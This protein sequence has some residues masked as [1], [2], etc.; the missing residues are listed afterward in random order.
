M[1]IA[2]KL[3]ILITALVL[4]APLSYANFCVPPKPPAKPA[5]PDEKCPACEPAECKKCTA[6]PVML[7]LGSYTRDETD[8]TIRTTGFGITVGRS[9]DSGRA[10]DGPMGIGWT[11]SLTSR[12][13]YAVYAL[14]GSTYQHRAVI[15]MPHGGIYEFTR[16]SSTGAFTPPVG[17]RDTLVQ[18]G[19]GTYDM[20]LGNSRTV[21]H[22]NADGTLS[23]MK[24]EFNNA[25]HYT[26]DGSGRIQRV[27]DGAGSGRFVDV[28]WNTATG[29]I[30]SVTD[31]TGRTV[32]YTYD[33]SGN[34]ESVANAVTPVGE[35]SSRYYYVA[36]RFKPLLSR[37]EDRWDR[38]ISRIEWEAGDKVK[39]YTDGDF[40]DGNPTASAGE[41]YRYFYPSGTS[42]QRTH[43]LGSRVY[44]FAAATGLK[45]NDGTTFNAS[46]QVAASF[47]DDGRSTNYT[48]DSTGRILTE[49]VH[50]NFGATEV[51][52]TYTYDPTF[53]DKI[54]TKKP[55]NPLL[56][57]GNRFEYWA[58]GNPA[59]G[60]LK[61]VYQIRTDGVTEDLVGTY[62]Y[63]A[64][65]R[66]LSSGATSASPA[67][68]YTYTAAGDL[69]TVTQGG[70]QVRYEYDAL[71]RM[72][73]SIDELNEETTY[74][75]DDAGR[76]LTLTRPKLSAMPALDFTTT[77]TY[78]EY[79][80]TTG[81]T[82]TKTTD[83]NGRVT[84]QGYDALGNLVK[85]VDALQNAT[86][87]TY[88]YNLLKS[89][90]DANDNTTSY[91][92]DFNRN[93]ISTTF[94]DGEIES[95]TRSSRGR[96]NSVTD[97]RGTTMSYAYDAFGRVT[98]ATSDKPSP[99][100][101]TYR[102][103]YSYE[104]QKLKM[105]TDQMLSPPKFY[106]FT[107][108]DRFQV[109][110]EGYDNELQV[111]Y[112]RWSSGVGGPP[113]SY[114]L[115]PPAG[116]T[117]RVT[118]V[119]YTYDSR[120]RVRTISFGGPT[121]DVTISY[122]DR[123]QYDEI[124]FG[125]GMVR[126]FTYDDQG[127]LTRVSHTH[128]TTGTIARH[129]YNYDFNHG[130]STWT[131][132]GQRVTMDPLGANPTK[133]RFDAAYQ[134][135]EE[136]PP[137]GSYRRYHY[138]A[139]GNRTGIEYPGGAVQDFEYYK[140]GSNQN[141]SRL[142]N[143]FGNTILTYDENGNQAN[144]AT[145][146][147]MN[148]LTQYGSVTFEYDWRS[149]R[150]KRQTASYS[151]VGKNVA[152][153][154]ETAT[155]VLDDFIFGAGLDE[156]L[157]RMNASGTK[158][159][160]AVDGLGSIVA[161]V[162]A[163]GATTHTSSYDAWGFTNS[164][165]TFGYTGRETGVGSLLYYRARYY[166]TAYGRFISEDAVRWAHAVTP[167]AYVHNDPLSF[168]DPEGMCDWEIRGRW[169][170][171]LPHSPP[172]YHHYLHNKKTGQSIGFS[173]KYPVLASFSPIGAPGIWWTDEPG[174]SKDKSDVHIADIKDE[175]CKC[176]G[177]KAKNPGS[178]P[179]YCLLPDPTAQSK[180]WPGGGKC[181]NCQTWVTNVLDDCEN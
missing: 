181:E 101:G 152:R 143:A 3:G 56:W 97:R 83:P 14:S 76:I 85:T 86:T 34:L 78:D 80:A 164:P 105:V 110:T 147:I 11:S 120:N 66:L 5:P 107:Y 111:E 79:D 171:G 178:P 142:K 22:F 82:F 70:D 114:T 39:S 59:P 126:K 137:N 92:Y 44:Q 141:T 25:I 95:Y 61:K 161:V 8:L 51:V 123:S 36:G 63:D 67:V 68:T 104:G 64:R 121:P 99:S 49:T 26:Y 74:T 41:K 112:E 166:E 7:S 42:T 176:V 30:S 46:G 23:W 154:R 21:L 6:S 65:G 134:L 9:Y 77:L 93:L 4:F 128:P 144:S 180:P 119:A 69:L 24:D 138:D 88:Q 62:V 149:R 40:N 55:N 172:F 100:G 72:T 98:G 54:A 173:T 38:V 125:N 162:D 84:K 1:R 169:T 148:R 47:D 150:T 177:D 156:P 139:I 2:G 10:V 43:S 168:F 124:E 50:G 122:D 127:R 19:D 75:Y 106:D 17:R 157:V 113:K 129:E 12:L 91:A 16:N 73:K 140:N 71:G 27:A 151:Y 116:S 87:Y 103:S 94:P 31:S 18:N 81:L 160:Y 132:L 145:W 135:I 20:T 57:P 174:P 131:M 89:I 159:Y 13:H 117:D 155:G 35:Y 158:S 33:A 52:W 37:I 108:D 167:Y 146:D 133:Y 179:K 175:S 29:R 170:K 32:R 58:P 163:A 102:I 15:V 53:P 28:T 90:T 60:A 165:Q 153:I 109:V 48:Y 136:L 118:K 45:S 96:L 115:R 130:D